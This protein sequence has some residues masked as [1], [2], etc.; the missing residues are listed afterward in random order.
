MD[1]ESVP[2]GLPAELYV[3]LFEQAA[4]A[5]FVAD[6]R[7]RL[8]A[9]NPRTSA[10]LGLAAED[11]L[12]RPLLDFTDSQDL[13]ENPPH[14]ADLRAGKSVV[15]ERLLRCRD[16]RLIPV[17]LTTRM[18]PD[19]HLLGVGRDTCGCCRSWTPTPTASTSPIP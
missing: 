7:G 4:D 12:G 5:M 2:P 6:P 17:E 8:I 15:T 3:S 19:G 18:L 1:P 16:G 11:M 14:L 9:V 10:M 13:L